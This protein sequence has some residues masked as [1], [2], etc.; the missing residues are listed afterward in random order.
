V[1]RGP[2]GEEVGRKPAWQLTVGREPVLVFEV[3]AHI[4]AVREPVIEAAP[5]RDQVVGEVIDIDLNASWCKELVRW[6]VGDTAAIENLA[7][8]GD[9]ISYVVS[10]K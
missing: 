1:I 2:D 5:E 3:A 9:P 8:R 4:D 10:E 7:I 6:E